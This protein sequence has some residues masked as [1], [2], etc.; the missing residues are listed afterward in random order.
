MQEFK[1]QV[2]SPTA[3]VP[4]VAANGPRHLS[5]AERMNVLPDAR[6]PVPLGSGTVVRVLGEGGVARVY[7]IISSRLGVH[8]A[9]KVL[10]PSQVS[11]LRQRFETEMRIT[12]QLHHPNIVQIH[13]VGDWHG[14]PYI[15]MELVQGVTLDKMIKNERALPLPVALAI[16]AAVCRALE[17]AHTCVYSADGVKHRG[18]LHH[19]LKP[20][21]VMIGNDGCVKLM[22]FGIATPVDV[23]PTSANRTFF[24]SLQYVAPEQLYGRQVDQRADLYSLGCVLYEMLCGRRV[25]PQQ[26]MGEIV[27][28]RYAN[29]F[30]RL[31][32]MKVRAP[33][34]LVS[35]AERCLSR[36][37]EARYESA[38]E[39][40]AQLER[41]LSRRYGRTPE[42]V[43]AGYVAIDP[44]DRAAVLRPSRRGMVRALWVT[45]LLM[46][47]AGAAGAGLY[48][49][50]KYG[51]IERLR[52]SFAP[53]PESVNTEAEPKPA[54][55]SSDEESTAKPKIEDVVERLNPK[56]ES[57]ERAQR[58]TR[59]SKPK[60]K[61]AASAPKTDPEP[62]ERPSEPVAERRLIDVLS[63]TYGTTDV[64]AILTEELRQ[65]QY[66]RALQLLDEVP[67]DALSPTR[68]LIYRVRALEGAGLTATMRTL[69][70][71]S[72]ANDAEIC[73]H[74]GR[75]L[76]EQR[77]YDEA[78]RLFAKCSS[79][80]TALGSGEIY[81]R[82]SVRLTALALTAKYEQT[83][84]ESA[85]EKA[86]EGWF[87]V[88]YAYR[89]QRDHPHFSEAN[90]YI[91]K[92]AQ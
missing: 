46:T 49:G 74:K 48:Y 56:P 11:Q 86:L 17:Y 35:I 1:P 83:G 53:P 24:G 43:M 57:H 52:L 58:P 61:P 82:E 9:V 70:L 77:R 59:P 14:L 66:R 29:R 18:V 38:G 80:P 2:V 20:A 69:L 75:I 65:G 33:Q 76:Y 62:Q 73:V 5:V 50:R 92:L 78:I 84:E 89:T 26:N 8:R 40:C 31:K 12:A 10:K 67:A 39:V 60:A 19:D 90:T 36:D 41:L 54:A 55:K 51:I 44:A 87:N 30:E 63:T 85:R 4:T 45:A 15:E 72:E 3:G 68:R 22:D 23:R 42:Q 28:A 34:A 64:S 27:T 21:N 81:A 16:G 7:E 71:Q 32:D 47:I 88:K 13:T 37:P 91:R 6:N 25:F 79:L